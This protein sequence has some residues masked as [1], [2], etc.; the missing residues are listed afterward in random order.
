MSR[1][2]TVLIF[3]TLTMLV[4]GYIG[5]CWRT[6]LIGVPAPALTEL[7]EKFRPTALDD[8]RRSGLL[9]REKF[10]WRRAGELLQNPYDTSPPRLEVTSPKPHLV[11]VRR[12]YPF[13]SVVFA[14]Y[15]D[16]WAKVPKNSK[17][18]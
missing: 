8:L 4:L 18:P 15:R 2:K 10:K 12:G 7:P 9:G 6:F 13:S 3:G 17:I 14:K 1:S 5:W 11:F 16:R